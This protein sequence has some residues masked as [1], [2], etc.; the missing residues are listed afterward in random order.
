MW[1]LATGGGK[2]QGCQPVPSAGCQP[3]ATGAHRLKTCA[4]ANRRLKTCTTS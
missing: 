2:I 1:P 3:A 4:T